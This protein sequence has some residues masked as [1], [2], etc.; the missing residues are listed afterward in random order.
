MRRCTLDGDLGNGLQNRN[1]EANCTWCCLDP[2]RGWP[3]RVWFGAP[4]TGPRRHRWD[5]RCDRISRTGWDGGGDGC[6]RQASGCGGG[7]GGCCG[8]CGRRRRWWL[9]RP[10][11]RWWRLRPVGSRVGRRRIP[12]PRG[13]RR[14]PR[15]LSRSWETQ[16]G[17][18]QQPSQNKRTPQIEFLSPWAPA[19][20]VP[21]FATRGS[22]LTRSRENAMVSPDGKRPGFC[23]GCFPQGRFSNSRATVEVII[24][25]A[26]LDNKL[27][28]RLPGDY[29]SGFGENV[30]GETSKVFSI[31]PA[32]RKHGCCSRQNLS[33]S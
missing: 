1:P 30:R 12:T 33:Q 15:H 9:L 2:W 17:R 19:S 14:R 3:C 4:G 18:E 8:R 13:R 16:S 23:P 32:R 7:G 29:R 31:P 24:V 27:L 25:S 11:W 20:Q 26:N 10:F 5:Q 22:L 21:R 6:G 28:R